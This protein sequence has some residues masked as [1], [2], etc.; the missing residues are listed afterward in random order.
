MGSCGV[1]CGGTPL[2]SLK[3]IRVV[4]KVERAGLG[5]GIS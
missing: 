5:W 4:A 2:G 3:G 1:G